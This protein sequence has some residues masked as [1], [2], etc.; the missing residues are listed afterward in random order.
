MSDDGLKKLNKID[1]KAIKLFSEL[2]E[3]QQK[4]IYWMMMGL[5]ISSGGNSLNNLLKDIEF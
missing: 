1:E 5:I 2:N 3:E 4:Q